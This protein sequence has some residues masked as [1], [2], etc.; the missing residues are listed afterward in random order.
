M[1]HILRVFLVGNLLTAVHNFYSDSR[2]CVRV[3]VCMSEWCFGSVGV[4]DASLC[5][6]T[7]VV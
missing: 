4:E 3:G 7:M 2:A 5:N 1:W 6:V